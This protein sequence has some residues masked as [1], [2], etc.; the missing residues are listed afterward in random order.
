MY[1]CKLYYF[2]PVL[3]LLLLYPLDNV[4]AEDAIFRKTAKVDV[5]RVQ[6]NATLRAIDKNIKQKKYTEA[7]AQLNSS[8]H[9]DALNTQLLSNLFY[10]RATI[11]EKIKRFDEAVADYTKILWLAQPR[12]EKKTRILLKR[13]RLL[14]QSNNIKDAK[15]DL[16]EAATYDSKNANLHYLIATIFTHENKHKKAIKHYKMANNYGY[17]DKAT[18][19]V[20]LTKNLYAIGEYDQAANIAT[21]LG[22]QYPFNSDVIALQATINSHNRNTVHYQKQRPKKLI[23]TASNI[24]S[25]LEEPQLLLPVDKLTY[26]SINKRKSSP[27]TSQDQTLN[28]IALDNN[29]VFDS[30]ITTASVS[31]SSSPSSFTWQTQAHRTKKNQV[32][33]VK[34]NNTNFYTKKTTHKVKF[35]HEDTSIASKAYEMLQ[36]NTG[37]INTGQI[38]TAP[39]IENI[40]P[41]NPVQSFQKDTSLHLRNGQGQ[42]VRIYPLQAQPNQNTLS[43]TQ[44][45]VKNSTYNTTQEKGY[46]PS[47][48]HTQKYSLDYGQNKQSIS[49]GRSESK[50]QI[51]NDNALTPKFQYNNASNKNG[52]RVQLGVFRSKENA[53]KMWSHV[54]KN[55]ASTLNNKRAY[56]VVKNNPNLGLRYYLQVGEY[57]SRK[58]AR[59]DCHLLRQNKFECLEI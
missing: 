53:V 17:R 14:I 29:N 43:N 54:Y 38:N 32:Q 27:Y 23:K 31:N 26:N 34:L 59:Y 16:E 7:L 40:T 9:D 51:L 1:R 42:E 48:W 24:S 15:A 57:N 8:I 50:E 11:F 33:K 41:K 19:K 18:L 21:A 44:N 10:K 52:M 37:Q 4:F 28:E 45:N 35:Q 5:S 30:D 2:L 20:A 49:L 39:F 55:N 3:G 22:K 6:L 25:L 58:D 13:A 56:I 46:N 47:Q 12:K 36:N